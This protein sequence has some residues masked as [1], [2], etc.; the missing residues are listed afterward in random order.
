MKSPPKVYLFENKEKAG[1]G[2]TIRGVQYIVKEVLK[3]SRLKKEVHPHTFRH[4][5][6]VHYIDNGGS[7][8]RLKELLGHE[9]IGTTFHYLKFCKM[10][11]QEIPTPLEVLLKRRKKP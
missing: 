10:P 3:R 9:D 7:I 1:Q 5:F 8:L 11:L 4:T 2:I 6:A